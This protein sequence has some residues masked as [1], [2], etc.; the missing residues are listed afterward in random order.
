MI[1]PGSMAS[2]PYVLGELGKISW[3]IC[4]AFL[5]VTNN[6]SKSVSLA[7]LTIFPDVS[8]TETT[9]ILILTMKLMILYSEPLCLF[10][11]S[12]CFC[13][14]VFW[15]FSFSLHILVVY[16][17]LIPFLQSLVG[18]CYFPLCPQKSQSRS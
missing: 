16:I 2:F 13:R 12:I 4:K 9:I 6:I 15:A 1:K 3:V 10:N 17:I 11:L 8:I 7:F 18:F 5:C 14:H